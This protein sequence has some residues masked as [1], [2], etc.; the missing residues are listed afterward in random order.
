MGHNENCTQLRN[1]FKCT[2][3]GAGYM[4]EYERD[5]HSKICVWRYRKREELHKKIK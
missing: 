1:K 4:I 5:K 3:C 2:Y